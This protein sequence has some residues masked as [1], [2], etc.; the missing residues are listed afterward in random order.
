[1]HFRI[2]IVAR[3][4]CATTALLTVLAVTGDERAFAETSR[5]IEELRLRAENA[6]LAFHMHRSKCHLLVRAEVFSQSLARVRDSSA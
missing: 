5:A 6:R 2:G 3:C 1:M 4:E